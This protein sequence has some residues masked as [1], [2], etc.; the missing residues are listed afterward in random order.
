VTPNIW[1]LFTFI[2]S[3]LWILTRFIQKKTGIPY[4]K[5]MA[6]TGIVLIGPLLGLMQFPNFLGL[7]YFIIYFIPWI[8][9]LHFIKW[10]AEN[11]IVTLLHLLDGT[12]TFVSL[13]YFSYFEQHVL[14][15]AIIDLFGF[16]YS[17]VIVKFFV[18]IFVLRMF[19]KYSDDKEFTNYLKVVIGLLGFATGLRS[20]LRLVVFV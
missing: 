12:T 13:E 16:T 2:I 17:F 1:L 9:L 3:L 19:D 18:I 8:I 5:I 20:L 11:K 7:F 6:I 4:Y 10:T 14:P 15:R